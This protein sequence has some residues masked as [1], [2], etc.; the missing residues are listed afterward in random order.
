[1]HNKHA[2]EKMLPVYVGGQS[3]WMSFPQQERKTR[4]RWLAPSLLNIHATRVKF[5]HLFT[6]LVK[7]MLLA[8]DINHFPTLV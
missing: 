1:M 5:S 4:D 8:A 6:N 7:F 2:Y 3:V